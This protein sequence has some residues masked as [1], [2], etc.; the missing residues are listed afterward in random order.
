MLGKRRGREVGAGVTGGSRVR[1]G[2]GYR[3]PDTI[4]GVHLA[5]ERKCSVPECWRIKGDSRGCNGKPE[6]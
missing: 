5:L 4:A 1:S 6:T 3:T 2:R